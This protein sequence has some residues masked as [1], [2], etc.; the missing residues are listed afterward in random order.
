MNSPDWYWSSDTS[1]PV[2]TPYGKSSVKP[3]L[4]TYSSTLFFG[5]S[6]LSCLFDSFSAQAGLHLACHRRNRSSPIEQS[7]IYDVFRDASSHCHPCWTGTRTSLATFSL[8]RPRQLASTFTVTPP[9][10]TVLSIDACIKRRSSRYL[11]PCRTFRRFL[12]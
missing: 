1:D 2:D 9:R 3:L 10:P 12:C 7:G 8:F 11:H 4:T 5:L 6:L